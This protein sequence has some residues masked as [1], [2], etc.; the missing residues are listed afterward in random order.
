MRYTVLTL[1]ET[2]RLEWRR[3]LTGYFRATGDWSAYAMPPCIILS[4]GKDFFEEEASIGN[5][6]CTAGGTMIWNGAASVL[7]VHADTLPYYAEN[8]GLFVSF[9]RPG[10]I[11][12]PAFQVSVG[13]LA[14]LEADGTSFR[15][16]RSRRL[17][18]DREP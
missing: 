4:C 15:V 17:R 10:T 3:M 12:F 1:D 6:I 18:K 13:S 2:P 14:L 16:I 8:P 9:S 7:P 11:S 5:G